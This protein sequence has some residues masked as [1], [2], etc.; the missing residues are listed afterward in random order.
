MQPPSPAHALPGARESSAGFLVALKGLAQ[1]L[2]GRII[3]RETGSQ[4]L[5]RPVATPGIAEIRLQRGERGGRRHGEQCFLRGKHG[6]TLR[7]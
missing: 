2:H 5:Q 4:R 6:P 7:A 1:A 3:T